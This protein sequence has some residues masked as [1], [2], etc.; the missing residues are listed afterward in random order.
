MGPASDALSI[1]RPVDARSAWDLRPVG[2][3]PP[4]TFARCAGTPAATRLPRV[5]VVVVA[6][7]LEG[8]RRV[9]AVPET[10]GKLVNAGLKVA[11]QAG[12]GRYAF[13][14]DEAY[15]DKGARIL[16]DRVSLLGSRGVLIKVQPPT[17]EE[18]ELLPEGSALICMLAPSSF[19]DIIRALAKRNITSFALELVPRT[20][21]AQSMDVLSSQA[22]V[23]GYRAAL[24]AARLL[25]KFF[26]MFMTAAGT[27]RPA[28]VFVLGAGVAGLQ[29][30]ATAHRLGAVV[31][32]YDVRAAAA[33]EVRS[34][35]AKFL[36]LEL[37]TQEGTGGYARAQSEDFIAK[38]RQLLTEHLAQ[39]DAVITTAAVP[40]RRAPILVTAEMVKVMRPGS[41][42]VDLAAD[43]GGNCEL[44]EAGRE[45]L[46]DGV[47]V[48]G[49][50]QAP[51]ELPMHASELFARNV[52]NLLLIMI[53][54]GEFAPDF[55]D[56]ILVGCCVTRDGDVVHPA[57][58][59]ALGLEARA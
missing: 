12:A 14:P 15:V 44:T 29:A 25:P 6:E 32:A 23:G 56:D 50:S 42:I 22:L 26:P 30:I 4:G 39:V 38:Q 40:G 2:G 43:S 51:S 41:V 52:T 5:E 31:D 45:I 54:D 55:A 46:V 3:H 16:D 9:A 8:E 49:M 11:V 19:P 34:L 33:E 10:V 48:Y 24:S 35:G 1:R 18:V 47:T 7:T 17:L 20:T 21:R 28:R 27:V 58:R 53:K 57:A 37:E 59:E 36:V 13:L